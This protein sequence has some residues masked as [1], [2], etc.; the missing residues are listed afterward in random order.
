MKRVEQSC[1]D[2]PL[3]APDGSAGDPYLDARGAAYPHPHGFVVGMRFAGLFIAHGD[4]LL[5]GRISDFPAST[6]GIPS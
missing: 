5:A 1:P 2:A 3:L 6:A 4:R